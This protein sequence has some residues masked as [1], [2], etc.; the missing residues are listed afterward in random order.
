MTMQILGNNALIKGPLLQQQLLCDTRFP[1]QFFPCPCDHQRC[2]LSE[3][4]LC[5]HCIWMRLLHGAKANPAH[6]SCQIQ[7]SKRTILSS[8][9]TIPQAL[10]FQNSEPFVNFMYIIYTHSSFNG[11]EATNSVT[12][13]WDA[14]KFFI[15]LRDHLWISWLSIATTKYLYSTT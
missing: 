1:R 12:S 15:V 6:P 13:E 11:Y 9:A 8:H 2:I 4:W 5:P 10:L 7:G 3:R 14:L